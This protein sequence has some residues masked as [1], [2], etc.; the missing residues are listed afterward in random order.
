MLMEREGECATLRSYER[1]LRI[2]L[3]LFGFR[4]L[5]SVYLLVKP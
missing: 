4:G 2:I 3:T 5:E 1:V